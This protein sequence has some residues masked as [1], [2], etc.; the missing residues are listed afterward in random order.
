[1]ED[2]NIKEYLEHSG[3]IGMKWG[4]RRYQN[5]D[6]TLTEE[7]KLRYGKLNKQQIDKVVLK[8]QEYSKDLVRDFAT[9]VNQAGN[10]LPNKRGSEKNPNYTTYKSTK[11]SNLSQKEL[12]DRINRM[13]LERSYGKLTGETR[14]V[15]SGEEKAREVFQTTASVITLGATA[16]AI[17]QKI[18]NMKNSRIK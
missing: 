3:L 2:C 4:I 7:G 5:P 12:S 13:N 17:A 15:K 14:Y 9:S 8:E 1:M 6:G 18:D 11:Y 16:L 10:I